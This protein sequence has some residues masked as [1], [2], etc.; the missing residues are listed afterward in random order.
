[1]RCFLQRQTGAGRKACRIFTEKPESLFIAEFI[2]E[3]SFL[4]LQSVAGGL[5]YGDQLIKL[6][7]DA[8]S[9][10]GGKLLMMRPERLRLVTPETAGQNADANLFDG[11]VQTIVFQGES[12]LFEVMLDGGHKVFVRMANRSENLRLLP[13][14]GQRVTLRLERTDARIVRA[15]D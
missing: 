15:E 5:A 9:T 4:P 12:L 1:M 6:A 8:P 2:G 13:Q 10:A 11:Q 3:S 14:A 7:E